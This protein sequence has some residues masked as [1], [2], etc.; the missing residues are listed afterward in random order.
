MVET[1]VVNASPIILLGKIGRLDILTFLDAKLQVPSTV[2]E[3]I[4][5]GLD[6]T[7]LSI[8]LRGLPSVQIVP[9]VSVP[10]AIAHWE[11]DAG[12]SQVLSIALETPNCEVLIDDLAARKCARTLGFSMIGTVGVIALC[13]KRGHIAAVRPVLNQLLESGL[14]LSDTVISQVL[15]SAG[16]A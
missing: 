10:P 14:R 9:Q 15:A 1:Y 8:E 6:G 16:E 11:L 3:E 4:S 13:K 7:A 2:V 5:V 12:E